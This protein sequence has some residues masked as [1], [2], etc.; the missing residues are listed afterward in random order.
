MSNSLLRSTRAVFLALLLGFAGPSTAPADD[1]TP[2]ETIPFASSGLAVLGEEALTQVY[3]VA[4]GLQ[5]SAEI[6]ATD[7]GKSHPLGP[8]ESVYHLVAYLADPVADPT[9]LR[10]SGEFTSCLADD[11]SSV[12]FALEVSLSLIDGSFLGTFHP[13]S[14]TGRY[15]GISGCPSDITTSG[16]ADLL[17]G[18]FDYRSEGVIEPTGQFR[19]AE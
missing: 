3:L 2:Q 6:Q 10:F 7:S 15:E 16:V 13:T 18:M 1:S 14:G 5:P 17:S 12:T 8:F 9:T 11:A 4:L 19:R